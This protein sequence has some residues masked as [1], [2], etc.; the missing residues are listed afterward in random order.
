MPNHSRTRAKAHPL[1]G[2][3]DFTK[4]AL[5]YESKRILRFSA[6]SALSRSLA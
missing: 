4:P 3:R 6:A 5:Y 1:L 2:E